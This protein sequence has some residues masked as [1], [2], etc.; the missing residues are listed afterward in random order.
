MKLILFIDASNLKMGGG[1]VHLKNLLNFADKK[2]HSFKKIVVC[3]CRETLENL[4]PQKFLELREFPVLNKTFFHRL[5]W[6]QNELGKLAE[7]E[8]AL[9]FVPGGLYLASYRPFVTMFQ[10][11]Q[12][13]ETAE[14]NREGFSKEW[15]RLHL[16]QFGQAQTFQN[17]TG[18]I[19]LS[20]YALNH[21][22]QF[23]PKL[24]KETK[25]RR[26]PHGILQTRQQSRE[27]RFKKTI[28]LL[29]VSTVKQYKHQWHLVDAVAL[30]KEQGFPLELHLIGSGDRHALKRMHNA[31][32]EKSYIGEFVYYHG[33][34]THTET[35]GWYDKV[36]I[37][38]Y[39]SSCENFPN[40]LMEA[41]AAGLPIA[42]SDKG[43]M[44][45]VLQDAGVYFN[46]E[47]PDSIAAS[48]N[49]LLQDESLRKT[50]GC[51]ALTLSQ[52]YSW[53]SSAHE[54]FSFLNSVYNSHFS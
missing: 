39:P 36:D 25:V 10:N 20:H 27:Y 30:L 35:L 2:K 19:C 50:L 40:I 49:L 32:Q 18:L 48:L 29:Y 51:R 5:V 16:L 54:T 28:K 41:M 34:L 12:I 22:Q 52:T 43:P 47:H 24:L 7:N 21:L 17:C 14:K 31:I 45:E 3:G 13:F 26:I 9:L 33:H 42:C 44:S 38:A 11:M 6:Q 53:E 4:S 37:F 46:P 1:L 15:L 8:N 23:Y